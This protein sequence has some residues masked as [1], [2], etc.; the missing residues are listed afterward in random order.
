MGLLAV[1]ATVAHLAAATLVGWRPSEERVSG[2]RAQSRRL[3]E[4][5]QAKSEFLRLASH[6]LR[7][8]V[9]VLRGYLSMLEDGSLGTLPP[10]A[11]QVMPILT[12]RVREMNLLLEQML[13]TARLEDSRLQLKLEELHLHDLVSET[14]ENLGY[15]ATDRHRVVVERPDAGS[16]VVRGDRD[17]VA[18]IVSNLV[19]N[20]IK[21]SPDGGEVVCR[22]RLEQERAIVSVADQ[23]IGVPA[24]LRHKLFTRFGRIQ[25]EDNAHIPGT[26]LGLYRSRELAR[27]HGGDLT[28]EALAERGSAF[29]LTLPTLAAQQP[30]LDRS[31]PLSRPG[32]VAE[33]P[34][35]RQ[36]EPEKCKRRRPEIA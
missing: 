14:V 18:T 4:L 2:L 5:E 23:G 31:A 1:F 9:G 6:E 28:Y 10:A 15:L 16:V 24:D 34:A 11:Q 3:E 20:A 13:D 12:G 19:H 27:M 33:A 35:V 7:S 25:T 22:V 21:Y 17:R 30:A 26:G 29:H 36:R 8:P 32:P